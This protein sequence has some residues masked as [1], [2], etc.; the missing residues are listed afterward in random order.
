MSR[1]K[2]RE[3]EFFNNPEEMSVFVLTTDLKPTK[4]QLIPDEEGTFVPG[5]IQHTVMNQG[6]ELNRT[7]FVCE[8]H[9]M[10]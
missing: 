10:T 7:L 4:M 5:W 6:M 8:T 9:C 2:K 1:Q 3:G